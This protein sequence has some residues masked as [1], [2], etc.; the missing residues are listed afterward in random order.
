MEKGG[1][2]DGMIKQTHLDG[3]FSP[4]VDALVHEACGPGAQERLPEKNDVPTRDPCFS[5]QSVIAVSVKSMKR[6]DRE[7]QKV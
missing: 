5:V 1:I 4:L 2:L 7:E 6:C 3:H